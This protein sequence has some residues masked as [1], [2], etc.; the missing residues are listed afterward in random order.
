[1][2]VGLQKVDNHWIVFGQTGVQFAFHLGNCLAYPIKRWYL[3]EV[4]QTVV[5]IVSE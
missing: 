1:M 5:E 3:V 2:V 4:V